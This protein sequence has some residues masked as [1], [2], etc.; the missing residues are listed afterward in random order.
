M[1]YRFGSHMSVAGGLH[2]AIDRAVEIGCDV[3]QIF[4]KR[5]T[6]FHPTLT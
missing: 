5:W 3:L 2:L 4:T 6:G 1:P